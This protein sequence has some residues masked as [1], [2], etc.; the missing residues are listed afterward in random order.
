MGR[1][2]VYL[3]KMA[4]L[5]LRFLFAYSSVSSQLGLKNN[6]K[7]S[8]RMRLRIAIIMSVIVG[9]MGVVAT[10]PAVAQAADSGVVISGLQQAGTAK[11]TDEFVELLNT[12][13]VAIDI[14][15]WQL[16]YRA[17]STTN[18]TDC[19]KGW[20]TKAT[21]TTAQI[22]PGGYYLFAPSI[23]LPADTSFSAGLAAAG[24]V[25]LLNASKATVDAVAWGAASCGTGHAAPAPSAGQSI[26]RKP[27][28]TGLTGDNAADFAVN[29]HP[30]A[31]STTAVFR[32]SAASGSAGPVP[33][34]TQ[35]SSP[36]MGASTTAELELTELLVDPAAPYSDSHDE[37]VEIHNPSS[38][39]VDATGYAVKTG[40]HTVPL[41]AGLIPAD[42]YIVLTSGATTLSLSNAGGVANLL[43]PAGEVVDTAGTWGAAVT[44]ASWANINNTWLWTLTPTPGAAN[45]FTPVPGKPGSEGSVDYAEISLSELF[46]DPAAPLTDAADEFIELYNPTDQ[47]VNLSGYSIKTGHDLG[48]KYII[49]DVTIAP[50]GFLALKSAL[51]KLALANDGSSVALYTPDGTQLGATVTY[52]KAASGNAWASF[53]DGWAW[54]AQPTPGAANARADILAAAAKAA[55]AKAATA[56]TKATA[57][58]A[59]AAAKPKAAKSTKTTAKPA[60][61]AATSTGGRWLLF[62]LAGLTLAYIIYEFRYDL[63]NYYYKLRGNPGGRPALVPVADGRGSD[64]ADQRPGRR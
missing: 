52:S 13:T 4:V 5:A 34:P 21:V 46:P 48:S 11:S 17:A 40:S 18:G 30:T 27:A 36:G 45:E 47:P 8:T 50:G 23:Y 6:S 60:L 55:A 63:R 57:A 25:R 35:V 20:T 3:L 16:Q 38:L 19:T 1:F 42:G 7:G 33:T 59:K 31:H 39:A 15:G 56:K 54:T 64:R 41:P 37:F 62:I 24:T 28:P 9:H 53:D 22:V 49:K 2:H 58:K 26:D 32:A 29:P 43:N 10:I 51:T 12:S 14:T 44:G 61:A